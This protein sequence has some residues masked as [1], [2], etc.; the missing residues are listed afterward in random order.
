MY[1]Q[2]GS[3]MYKVGRFRGNGTESRKNDINTDTDSQLGCDAIPSPELPTT[4]PPKPTHECAASNLKDSWKFRLCRVQHERAISLHRRISENT[5][6]TPRKHT[7]AFLL[8]SHTHTH[9]SP[10]KCLA[11]DLYDSFADKML[12]IGVVAL[13]PLA[14]DISLVSTHRH[15]GAGGSTRCGRTLNSNQRHPCGRL[16]MV[17]LARE[18]RTK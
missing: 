10:L 3:S 11:V 8:H 2:V 5:N 4:A 14:T 16:L 17:T 15:A 13:R 9:T 7:N 6:G 1:S 18:P 12:A